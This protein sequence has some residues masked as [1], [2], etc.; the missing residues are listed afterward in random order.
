MKKMKEMGMAELGNRGQGDLVTLPCARRF[1]NWKPDKN[2]SISPMQGMLYL[3]FY[4][5]ETEKSSH[6][7]DS[8]VGFVC[9]YVHS[10]CVHITCQMSFST[11][12]FLR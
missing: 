9:E 4:R 2:I 7:A 10:V 3:A 11:R 6:L 12:L 5:R 8:M 1:V